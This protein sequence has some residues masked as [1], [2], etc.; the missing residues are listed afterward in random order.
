ME[1]YAVKLNHSYPTSKFDR[2]LNTLPSD[3]QTKIRKFLRPED[4]LR[5]LAGD[6]LIRSL[7]KKHLQI[8]HESITFHL[9][10]Y[11]KPYLKD[12]PQVH[13]N[14]SHSGNWVVCGLDYTPIG[15]DVEQMK[16]IKLD[17]AE[18]FF[19]KK[20][21]QYV[22]SKKES[23]RLH[24]F[25]SIWTLKESYIKAI[26]KGL[27]IPLDSFSFVIDHLG[28]PR[29]EKSYDENV[30][31]FKQYVLDEQHV[32]SVCATD[33]QFVDTPTIIALEELFAS[34]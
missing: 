22:L 2:L 17:I 9:N 29:L 27:S 11:G 15:I 3:R 33:N 20:E 19:T 1:I 6:I 31:F 18:R 24:S 32:C 30:Y 13:F 14:I 34:V 23:E 21:S 12:F 7:L 4:T 10:E 28:T 26:G 16:S 8:K 5:T 25:Y